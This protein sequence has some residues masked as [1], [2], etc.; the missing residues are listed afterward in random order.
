MTEILIMTSS[1][2]RKV[3]T[4]AVK[5]ATKSFFCLQKL[6]LCILDSGFVVRAYDG[7]VGVRRLLSNHA[8]R[9]SAV[10]ICEFFKS[11]VNQAFVELLAGSMC[12]EI[13]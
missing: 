5:L 6:K 3:N 10:S 9:R 12:D 2:T 11:L 4:I 7:S 1:M 8:S 13:L